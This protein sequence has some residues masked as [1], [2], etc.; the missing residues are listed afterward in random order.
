[1]EAMTPTALG[2]IFMLSFSH[3][4][5]LFTRGNAELSTSSSDF[6]SCIFTHKAHTGN[7]YRN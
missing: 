4:S 5:G 2:V 3:F 6:S 7:G 1:M